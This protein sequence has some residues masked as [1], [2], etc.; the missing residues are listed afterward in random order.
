MD[1]F[2]MLSLQVC[3][4]INVYVTTICCEFSVQIQVPCNK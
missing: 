1:G 2:K 4:A 3:I